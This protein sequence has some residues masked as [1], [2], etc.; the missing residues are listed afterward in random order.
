MEVIKKDIYIPRGNSY[1]LYVKLT[2]AGRPFEVENM[3]FTIKR[4]AS[5]EFI[6]QKKL[7]DGITIKDEGYY[8][9]N[10]T[11]EETEEMNFNN[12]FKYDIKIVKNSLEK[13]IVMGDF[14]VTVDYTRRAEQ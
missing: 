3:Y 2:S 9:I 7:N 4:D 12:L 11:A 1:T 8:L 14:M 10:L 6:K 5:T 13:T